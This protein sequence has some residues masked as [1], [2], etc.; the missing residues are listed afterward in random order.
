MN[1]PCSLPVPRR[2]RT[3]VATGALCAL[4]AAC[5]SGGK[6]GVEPEPPPVAGL[7]AGVYELAGVA[8]TLPTTDLAPFRQIVGTTRFVALGESTHASTGYYQ[9]KARLVRFMVEEMG[10]RVVVWETPWLDAQIATEYVRSCT[11]TP[12]AALSGMF[13]VWRDTSVRDLLRWLCEYNR[14]HPGDPVTFFG[15]D[16]QEPWRSAPAVRAFVQRAA[17]DQAARAEPLFGCLGARL[18][19][20]E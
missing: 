13:T 8:P 10:F 15:F 19:P 14:G 6:T 18:Q 12:E 17:P 1:L 7:P 4:L 9:A 16:I 3:G 20:V 2:R 11:G 5:S